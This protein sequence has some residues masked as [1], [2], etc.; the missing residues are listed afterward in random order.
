MAKTLNEDT[1]LPN[2]EPDEPDYETRKMIAEKTVRSWGFATVEAFL[3]SRR[4]AGLKIDPATAEVEWLFGETLNPYGV[5]P[6]PKEYGGQV[7]R[8]YFARAPGSG[9]WVSF[10]DLPT[11]TAK[12]LQNRCPP[13][14]TITTQ[15]IRWNL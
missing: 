1:V 3:A 15:G 10:H 12:A 14:F 8:E 9:V 13:S 5:E 4:E 2:C 7:G 6:L 11:A